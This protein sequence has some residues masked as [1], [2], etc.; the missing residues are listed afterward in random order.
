MRTAVLLAP[1]VGDA[2]RAWENELAPAEVRIITQ[3]LP[4]DSVETGASVVQATELDAIEWHLLCGPAVDVMVVLYNQETLPEG[5]RN[6]LGLFARLFLHLS[7]TGIYVL[8]RRRR[9]GEFGPVHRQFLSALGGDAEASVGVSEG[10]REAAG[11]VT[12]TP[13]VIVVDKRVR[14]LAMLRDGEAAEVLTHR[15]PQLGPEVL[16][17][18]PPSETIS[19]ARITVHAKEPIVNLPEMMPT[20]PLAVRHYRG[21]LAFA[22]HTVLSTARTIMPDAF[23]YHLAETLDNPIVTRVSAR[24]A[25]LPADLR[26]SE[27][28]DGDYYLLD[29]AYPGHFG[30]MMTDVVSRLWGWDRAKQALPDLRV[31]YFKAPGRWNAWE[32]HHQ[33]LTSYGIDERDIVTVDRPVFLRSV[34][35]ATP[36]W[37]NQ[38]PYHAHSEMRQVWERL[39]A[40]LVDPHGPS[41]DKVFISRHGEWDQRSCRNIREVEDVF[42]AA[43]FEVFYPDQHPFTVQATTFAN[44][45]VIAG[46][47]GSGLFNMLFCRRLSTLIVLGH[48]GYTARNEHLFA[49]L[50]GPDV[51]YF[52]SEP[53]VAHPPGGWSWE[54]FHSPWEFDFGRFH[55]P[56]AKLLADT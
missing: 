4:D 39:G 44:A 47:C 3:V 45:R 23:R 29:S 14:H 52:W 43:G 25:T 49:S 34:V 51:H 27:T 8:P 53:D 35:G 7:S 6:Q 33:L 18:K 5:V 1:E 46:F 36:M 50:L 56:L 40:A 9:G 32:V 48:E 42:A 41:Y 22:G 26:P 21:Q 54:G 17:T 11:G 37:H 13:E 16:L 38:R 31:L 10:V 19:T 12:V 15:E 55:E 24:F 28:L 20:P 2:T 30:H